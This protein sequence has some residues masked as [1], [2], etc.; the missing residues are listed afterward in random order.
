MKLRRKQIL[1]SI[2]AILTITTG[3]TIGV[4]V[5]NS[6]PLW[7]SI[8]IAAVVIVAHTI[9]IPT[10][11]SRVDGVTL[12]QWVSIEQLDLE[13][14]SRPTRMQV[15]A[16]I[17]ELYSIDIHLDINRVEFLIEDT[18]DS[19]ILH[20][21]KQFNSWRDIEINIIDTLIKLIQDKKINLRHQ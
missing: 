14:K 11:Q 2:A 18:C 17:R 19:A 10:I 12:R 13:F 3:L 1:L 9:I 20:K 5:A 6:I 7:V 15:I 8:S 16:T 21:S 4:F